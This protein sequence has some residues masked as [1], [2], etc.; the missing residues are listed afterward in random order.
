MVN[1][2]LQNMLQ[3][4]CGSVILPSRAVFRPSLRYIPYQHAIKRIGSNHGSGRPRRDHSDVSGQ[5]TD[6]PSGQP[7]ALPRLTNPRNRD[8]TAVDLSTSA[9][10]AEYHPPRQRFSRVIFAI[11]YP[12]SRIIRSVFDDRLGLVDIDSTFDDMPSC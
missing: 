4:Y 7:G 11:F 9:V 8:V 12:Y 3:F 2:N 5:R 1:K 10:P 6:Q